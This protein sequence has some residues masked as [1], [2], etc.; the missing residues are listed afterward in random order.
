MSQT[1]QSCTDL[2]A[3]LFPQPATVP[4]LSRAALLL[5]LKTLRGR[6]TTDGVLEGADGNLKGAVD[7]WDVT[8]GEAFELSADDA[9]EVT[10]ERV[11]LTGEPLD[12]GEGS[13]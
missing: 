11:R 12:T 13:G 3:T 4:A 7:D 10:T 8:I 5:E 9:F 2:S 1:K 6:E